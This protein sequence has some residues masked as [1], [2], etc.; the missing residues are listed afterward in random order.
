M[1]A[2]RLIAAR[3]QLFA[4]QYENAGE[5]RDHG[6]HHSQTEPEQAYEADADKINCEQKHADVFCEVHMSILA[7]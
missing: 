2:V 3:R 7:V 1:N 5:Q 4:D 6:R